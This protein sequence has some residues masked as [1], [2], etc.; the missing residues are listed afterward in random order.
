MQLAVVLLLLIVVLII[1]LN[2]FKP[3][4]Y[5]EVSIGNTTV[6]AEIADT[7]LK[8]TKG[9]MGK[10]TLKENEA[11]LFVFDSEGYYRFWMMNMSIPIDII[12]ISKNKTVVDILKDAQPCGLSCETYTPKEKAMYVLEVKANFTERHRIKIGS[13]VNFNLN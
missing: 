3:S 5:T 8:R 4:G 6:N 1:F 9:L 7:V 10:K 11:M 12:F 13:K 2:P